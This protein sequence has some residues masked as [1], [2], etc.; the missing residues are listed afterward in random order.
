MK[1]IN[2][3]T[4][5]LCLTENLLFAQ[6]KLTLDCRSSMINWTGHAQIGTYAPAGTLNFK[7]G[8]ATMNDG[9]I[10]SGFFVIDM[11][12]MKQDNEHLLEHLKS[13]DFFDVESYPES[14]IRIDKISNNQAYGGLT[15]KGRSQPF[16]CLVTVRRENGRYIISGKAVIDR[17]AY[18][19]TYNSDSFFTGLGD[20]AISNTFDVSFTLFMVT[21]PPR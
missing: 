16:N 3:F 6:D 2:I 1:A 19:V 10:K 21:V 9:A 11:K 17:T 5:I 13:S 14:T 12:S 7:A 8:Q 4:L 20:K 15:I 18:G